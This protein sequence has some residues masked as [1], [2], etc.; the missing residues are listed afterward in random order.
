MILFVMLFVSS[1]SLNYYEGSVNFTISSFSIR[2][3]IS[4][5]G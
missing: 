5:D 4:H 2:G 1:V 3:A